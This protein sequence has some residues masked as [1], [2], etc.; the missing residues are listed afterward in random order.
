MIPSQATPSWALR[1]YW[2][3]AAR[4]SRSRMAAAAP[5][6]ESEGRLMTRPVDICSWSLA[7]RARLACS[8]ASESRVIM[9]WVIRVMAISAPR[10]G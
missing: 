8:D 9:F 6:G 1:W 2:P 4:S 10:S 5:V 7:V 3:V